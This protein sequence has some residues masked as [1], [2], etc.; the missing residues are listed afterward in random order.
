MPL[1]ASGSMQLTGDRIPSSG[2]MYHW[3]YILSPPGSRKYISYLV[4]WLTVLGWQATVTAFA[5][6]ASSLVGGLIAEVWPLYVSFSWHEWLFLWAVLLIAILANTVIGIQLPRIEVM[7]LVAY[8]VC[9]FAI[10]IPMVAMSSHE[11]ASNVFTTFLNRGGWSSQ[12]LSFWVGMVGNVFAFIG[13]PNTP[14]PPHRRPSLPP[15]SLS[16]L[17]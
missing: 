9:F 7:I 2:G 1:P 10:V 17:C 3:A 13:M 5:F 16:L 14:A 15:Y 12:G 6:Q 8:I 4:G 11:S